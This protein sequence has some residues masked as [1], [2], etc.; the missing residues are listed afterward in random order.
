MSSV[1]SGSSPRPKVALDK[2]PDGYAYIV[3]WISFEDWKEDDLDIQKIVQ[4]LSHSQTWDSMPPGWHAERR[5]PGVPGALLWE[6]TDALYVEDKRAKI[7][8]WDNDGHSLVIR[9]VSNP[10][11]K[12]SNET[13]YKTRFLS[14]G[15]YTDLRG[16]LQGRHCSQP[17]D[18]IVSMVS[19]GTLTKEIVLFPS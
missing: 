13:R 7:K 12:K 16:R 6:L 5:F 17:V 19:G 8:L 3:A 10:M 15:F 1:V 18:L 2:P 11:P 9:D 4:C 14:D